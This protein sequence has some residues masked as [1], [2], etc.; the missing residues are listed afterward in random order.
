MD[1]SPAHP[2]DESAMQQKSR[3]DNFCVRDYRTNFMYHKPPL[4]GNLHR[5]VNGNVS[6]LEEKKSKPVSAH[7]DQLDPSENDRCNIIYHQPNYNENNNG[8]RDPSESGSSPQEEE[9]VQSQ[10][11][12]PWT[13]TIFD[14]HQN[15]T[16]ALI[17]ALSPCVTFGQIAEIITGGE[18]TC[19]LGSCAYLLM[20]PTPCLRWLIGAKYRGK[21]RSKYNLVEAPFGDCISHLFC[22]CCSLSQE[23]RELQN[24]GLDPNLGWK[25]ILAQQQAVQQS[26]QNQVRGRPAQDQRH[27]DQAQRPPQDQVM[28]T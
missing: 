26:H 15:Q 1:S 21:L 6:I 16:N 20:M 4:R 12:Q 14:C 18:T 11:A 10:I 28:S 19:V 13:T 25:G 5:Q 22:S 24:R 23:F 8:E 2:S 17:T 27:Q 7:T 3:Q 9:T